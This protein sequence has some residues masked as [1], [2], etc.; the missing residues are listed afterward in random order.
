MSR[1]VLRGLAWC[2]G[3]AVGL[4][5][6]RHRRRWARR[7]LENRRPTGDR[8]RAF[9]KPARQLCMESCRRECSVAFISCLCSELAASRGNQ[10]S[11]II[12]T[13]PRR[14][15]VDAPATRP[16]RPIPTMLIRRSLHLRAA[17][18]TACVPRRAVGSR[19]RRTGRRPRCGRAARG[20]SRDNGRR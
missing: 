20:A 8:H 14:P 9:A 4:R 13:T 12:R 15:A 18:A 2:E 19:G 5:T 17:V 1:A 3:A 7:R 16:I 6:T 11:V 10:V